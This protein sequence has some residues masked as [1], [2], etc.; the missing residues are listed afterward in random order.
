MSGN[1]HPIHPIIRSPTG[2]DVRTKMRAIKKGRPRVLQSHNPRVSF[3]GSFRQLIKLAARVH[4]A[5]HWGAM[6]LANDSAL[7]GIQG[8][9]IEEMYPAHSD[10]GED[11]EGIP[12]KCQLNGD[13]A[14]SRKLAAP[15]GE[16]K[17]EI[18]ILKERLELPEDWLAACEPRGGPR[19]PAADWTSFVISPTRP[20]LRAGICPLKRSG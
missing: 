19:S 14:N 20:I 1:M 16:A 18:R 8:Y 13:S 6:H 3:S 12:L 7:V 10:L 5:R 11:R 9:E 4:A 17:K 2:E 15:L